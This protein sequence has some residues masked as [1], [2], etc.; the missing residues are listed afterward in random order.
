MESK[1]KP[2]WKKK[3]RRSESKTSLSLQPLKDLPG[4]VARLQKLT[5][6]PLQRV[7]TEPTGQTADSSKMYSSPFAPVGGRNGRGAN[8]TAGAT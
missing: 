7:P 3:K 2:R 6:S 5:L 4:R 1:I 8:Q